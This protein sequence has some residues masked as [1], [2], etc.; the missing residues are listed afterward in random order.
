M[1]WNLRP[2]TLPLLLAGLGAAAAAPARTPLDVAR[3]AWP[4]DRLRGETRMPL[5]PGLEFAAGD[6]LVTGG[7]GRGTLRFMNAGTLTLGADG[8]LAVHSFETPG[9]G[10][11]GILRLKLTRGALRVDSR[12]SSGPP[13]DVRLNVADLRLRVFGADVWTEVAGAM[14]TVCLVAGAVELQT[15]RGAERIDVPG[16]CLVYG[17]NGRRQQIRTD[18][19]M[20][21]S[22]LAQTAYANELPAQR[23]GAPTR[24]VPGPTPAPAAASASGWTL[25]LASLAD[26]ESARLE[27]LGLVEQGLPALVRLHDR[28]RNRPPLYRVCLGSFATREAA[29]AFAEQVRRSHGLSELWLAQY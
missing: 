29:A 19:P 27:A 10:H 18:R 17:E 12:S 2:L 1:D 5:D 16:D 13:P 7:E 26:A 9:A 4:A 25:V 24:P 21:L 3:M 15:A 8:E 11:S 20:L 23:A 22:R 14:R 28:G 6:R